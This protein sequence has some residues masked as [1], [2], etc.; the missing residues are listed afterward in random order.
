MADSK[1]LVEVKDLKEYFYRRLY[2]EGHLY[3][4]KHIERYRCNII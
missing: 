3:Y 4:K 2:I 1:Y